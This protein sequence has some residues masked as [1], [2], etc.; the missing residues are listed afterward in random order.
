MEQGRL[1]GGP[2]PAVPER[3][4]R[5]GR[6]DVRPVLGRRLAG[7]RSGRSA[8]PR[9]VHELAGTCAHRA[10]PRS[11]PVR[12]SR[13]SRRSCSAAISTTPSRARTPATSPSCSPTRASSSSPA[14]VTTPCS[15]SVQ[16]AHRPSCSGSWTR[17][18]SATRAALVAP[19]WSSRRSAGFRGSRAGSGRRSCPRAREIIRRRAGAGSRRRRPGRSETRWITPRRAQR[20]RPPRRQLRGKFGDS[21]ARPQAH[22]VRF[23]QDVTV[24][25]RVTLQYR[26][27][28]VAKLNVNGPSG[29]SGQLE[30]TGVYLAPGATSLKIAGRLGGRRVA[31]AI[32]AT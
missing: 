19:A 27:G 23:T 9:P 5:V 7:R 26:G 29:Q 6:D 2:A 12:H 1:P 3:Q 25:G 17:A 30:I 15:A 13:R 24:S 21:R 11:R 20:G 14:P 22:R 18:R 10:C 16:A 31:L 32:P 8:R 28:L 4:S